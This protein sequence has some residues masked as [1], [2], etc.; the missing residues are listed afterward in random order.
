MNRKVN[1]PSQ[2]RIS[3]DFKNSCKGIRNYLAVLVAAAI[4]FPV[5]ASA[6][7]VVS[8]DP[9][10][11][12]SGVAVSTAVTAH[13]SSASDAVSDFVLSTGTG[14]DYQTIAGSWAQNGADAVFT[15]ASPLDYS[16][17]YSAEVFFGV[18]YDANSYSWS[19]TTSGGAS[20]SDGSLDSARNLGTLTVQKVFTDT[21]GGSDVNDYYKF[22]TVSD[23]QFRLD[24][25]DL[26]AD[27]DVSLLDSSGTVINSSTSG[28]S[29]SESISQDLDSGTYY[30]RVFPYSGSTGYTLKLSATAANAL[31]SVSISGATSVNENS[32]SDYTLTAYYSDGS[33]RSVTGEAS[34]SDN[35]SY[36]SISAAGVLTS[37][38]VDSDQTITITASYGGKSDTHTVTIKDVQITPT[39]S[40][41]AINGA[42][43]VYENSSS[44]YTLTVNYSDGTSQTISDGA[45]WSVDSSYASISSGGVLT[46]LSVTTDISVTITAG[47]GGASGTHTVSVINLAEGYNLTSELWANAVLETSAGDISLVWSMVGWDITP[48]GDQVI[49]GYF[50]ADPE[51]FAYGSLYN[52]EVFVKIY[53]TTNGWCNI[54]FNHVT[55]DPVAIYTAHNYAGSANQS[56][57]ITIENRLAQH[58]Y[59]GV[60]IDQTLDPAGL[61]QTLSASAVDGGYVLSSD[62]WAKAVLQ[63]SANPVTLIWKEVGSDVTPSGARVVSGYFYA[64]PD[65]FAYG[66]V[67]NPEVFVKVY[68]AETGW[69]N[70]AFNHVT[71]DDVSL[72]SAHQYS[73]A[74]SKTGSIS[75]EGRLAEHQFDINISPLTLKSVAISGAGSVNENSSSGYTLTASYT[76]GTSQT[77]TGAA[78]WSVTS[79]F[80]SI[81]ANG[82]LTAL[83]VD[84]DQ[85][86][87]ITASYGGQSATYAVIIKDAGGGTGGK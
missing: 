26:S 38:A 39:V 48:T 45:S 71:V 4:L 65:V 8:T 56:G 59:N 80:A 60:S 84:S 36:A 6:A 43:A 19:F 86:V 10:S 51:D 25:M 16:T 44:S 83:S 73:G 13:M 64:D 55:V 74:A 17:T 58:E 53:I 78:T 49:S 35:S 14:Y 32:S 15:P 12:A 41:V 34:W 18:G 79:S 50:Y 27:A 77:V 82:V 66:S 2:K 31:T 7:S 54:A 75:L 42:T 87:S 70:I 62:L 76:D 1:R 63:V 47:Y 23:T 21:I 30:V 3:V 33:S 68:V 61:D 52:P 72:Y 57:T 85:A 5:T 37:Y 69:A 46:T 29:A 22:T 40:S 81:D 28:G 9:G 20:D 11:N 24:L 67:Y